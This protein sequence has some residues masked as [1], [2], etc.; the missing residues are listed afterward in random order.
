MGHRVF[1]LIL[2]LLLL[3]SCRYQVYSYARSGY[4][5]GHILHSGKKNIYYEPGRQYFTLFPD[6]ELDDDDNV[7]SLFAKSVCDLGVEIKEG[8]KLFTKQNAII[9]CTN[10]RCDTI[11]ADTSIITQN[12]QLPLKW[13]II[14]RFEM[15][16][17]SYLN[18]DDLFRA[19][20][21]KDSVFFSFQNRK[22]EVMKLFNFFKIEQSDSI[23]LSC[24]VTIGFSSKN[25]LPLYMRFT[26]QEYNWRHQETIEALDYSEIKISKKKLVKILL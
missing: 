3:F 2:S 5:A 22:P 15:S 1:F 10:N 12:V 7:D 16:G 11:L 23:N 18:T 8:F 9:Y 6:K 4:R 14:R 25:G 21:L 24:P 26:E 13:L 19:K 17:I 20:Y